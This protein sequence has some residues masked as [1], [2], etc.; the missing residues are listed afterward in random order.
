VIRSFIEVETL[1]RTEWDYIERGIV[2]TVMVSPLGNT[3]ANLTKVETEELIETL[4]K[5]LKEVADAA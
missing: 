3:C 4:I 2:L 1:P 5:T